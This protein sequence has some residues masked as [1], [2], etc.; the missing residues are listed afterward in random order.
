MKRY[1]ILVLLSLVFLLSGCGITTK[2][3]YY[4]EYYRKNMNFKENF[5]ITQFTDLH[6]SVQTDYKKVSDYLKKNITTSNPDL[7]VFTGDSFMDASKSVVSNVLDFI[8]SFNIPFA[9]TYGNHDLQGSYDEFFINDYIKGLKNSVF[10]DF[11]DDNLYGLTNYY[12]DLMDGNSIKYRLFII[13]SNSYHFNGFDY[14]YDVIHEDQIAHLENIVTN[15]GKVPS[16]AFYHIPLYEEYDAYNLI[17]EGKL[18]T[19]KGAHNEKVSK[20]YKRTDAFSRMKNI[21]V[22][23]HFF[24]HDHINYTDTLYQDVTLSYGVKSTPEIYNYDEIIGYKELTLKSD[25]SYG[26]DNI[27]GVFV[28][29]E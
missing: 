28:P 12:I 22:V 3:S 14:D 15:E 17:K 4:Y 21:G 5:K 13:D 27:K 16:F 11:N 2:K 24:G 6:F 18:E 8:D 20:G 10:V 26:L 1:K 9:F 23:G 19:Y 7:M 29:Y 25:M